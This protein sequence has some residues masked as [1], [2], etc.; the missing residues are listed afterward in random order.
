[1]FFFYKIGFVFVFFMLING[2]AQDISRRSEYTISML[3]KIYICNIQQ[4]GY[5]WK[6][7]DHNKLMAL[8]ST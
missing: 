1:M 2:Y 6:L 5:Y 4:L 8:Y 7:I 3:Y